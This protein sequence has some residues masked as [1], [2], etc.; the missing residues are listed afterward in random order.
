MMILKNGESEQLISSQTKTEGSKCAV[1]QKNK[2]QLRSRRSK[3][4][5]QSMFVCNDCFTR[6]LEPR[7]LIIITAQSEGI[8]SVQEYLLSR[9]YVGDE[10]PAVDL[11]PL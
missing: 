10:I 11:L 4:N 1:C 9:K 7:W 3:L 2:F 5:G 6:K 8:D